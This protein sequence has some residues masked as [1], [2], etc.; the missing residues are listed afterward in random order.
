MWWHSIDYLKWDGRERGMLAH[1]GSRLHE[2][3][4]LMLW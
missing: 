2:V 1:R 4:R 3:P